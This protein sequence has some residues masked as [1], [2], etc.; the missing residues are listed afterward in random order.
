MRRLRWLCP[1]VLLPLVA[2]T[3][4]A[5]L[6]GPFGI[7][8]AV[9]VA[10]VVML[11]VLTFVVPWKVRKGG[12]VMMSVVA[13]AP[14]VAF[15]CAWPF[16]TGSPRGDREWAPD[17]SRAVTAEVDGDKLVV[18][19]VRNFRWRSLSD[20]DTAWEDRTYDLARI[21]RVWFVLV[22]FHDQD[23]VAHTLLSF[24]FEGG[25]FLAVSPEI[26]KERGESFSASGGL[27]RNFEL[28]YTVGDERDM[29]KL[30]T[31]FFGDEVFVFPVKGTKE[32]A[33]TALLDVVA[34]VNGL[35]A[36]P[37]WYDAL[38]NSCAVNVARH[39]NAVI[40]GS[41][42]KSWR[43]ALPGWS[44]ELALELGFIDFEGTV[45][46]ARARFKANE[47][48]AAAGDS[49]DFSTL[50]RELPSP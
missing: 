8:S 20:Y 47:K 41:I 40:P 38:T 50:I 11:F 31:D 16:L 25:E 39:A 44:D 34:R 22:P 30:R 24:E 17:V 27:F 21:V 4:G 28:F 29:V 5:M 35:A 43:V 6:F 45:P 26:R 18:H 3:A 7:G 2:W 42:G 46:E 32:G 48:A 9:R 23:E 10:A 12:V 14:S 13:A 37:E 36:Q 49:P 15:A 19:D 33:R 1:I